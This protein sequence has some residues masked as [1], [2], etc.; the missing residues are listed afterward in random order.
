MAVVK[1]ATPLPFK[2]TTPRTVV[3]SR[4]VTRPKG[5]IPDNSD[6]E[7][8]VNV[9]ACPVS[10]GFGL[11]VSVNVVPTNVTDSTSVALLVLK[12]VELPY[13]AVT[14]WVPKVNEEILNTADPLALSVAVPIVV[15]PSSSVTL[16]VGT[17]L[18]PSAG[19]TVVVKVM[20]CPTAAG[21]GDAVSV[22]TL[23]AAVTTS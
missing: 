4:K 5:V 8:A 23:F 17:L 18:P 14:V 1:V 11:A 19:R 9:T 13:C 3:P 21:F 20:V 10:E 22:V 6:A 15:E 12:F 2:G 16:P 7:V